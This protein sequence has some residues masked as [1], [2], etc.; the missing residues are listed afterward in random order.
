MCRLCFV[1]GGSTLRDLPICDHS[2]RIAALVRPCENIR[3]VEDDWRIEHDAGHSVGV[4]VEL[5]LMR[6]VYTSC[7]GCRPCGGGASDK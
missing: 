3:E 4:S 1:C 2:R 7:V 5:H 6:H